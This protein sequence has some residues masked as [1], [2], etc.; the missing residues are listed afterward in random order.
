MTAA[1]YQQAKDAHPDV[2]T[3]RECGAVLEPDDLEWLCVTCE[4]MHC[5]L[6]REEI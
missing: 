5:P 4:D 3:C 1:D 2:D 6:E